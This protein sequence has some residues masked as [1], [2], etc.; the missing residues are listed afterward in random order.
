MELGLQ[1]LAGMG[2]DDPAGDL[3]HLIEQAPITATRLVADRKLLLN[4][5]QQ[6][7]Q[8]GLR[9]PDRSLSHLLPVFVA[10]TNR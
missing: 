5:W 6:F 1:P 10:D 3:A 8:N 2:H 9:C 4:P 7:K